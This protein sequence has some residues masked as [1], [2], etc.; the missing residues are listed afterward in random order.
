MSPAPKANGARPAYP[1]SE[2]TDTSRAGAGLLLLLTKSIS[3]KPRIVKPIPKT[4]LRERRRGLGG[5]GST[6]SEV[7]ASGPLGRD[8]G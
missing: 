1:G 7:P 5:L 8:W 6:N 4:F 3:S 2:R